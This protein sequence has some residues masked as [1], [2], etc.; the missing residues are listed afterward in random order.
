MRGLPAVLAALALVLTTGTADAQDR[1]GETPSPVPGRP[2]LTLDQD[3]L[4]AESDFGRRVREEIEE[5]ARALGAENRR[6]ESELSEEE[7]ALTRKRDEMAADAFR[8]LADAFDARV[9]EI[10]ER[11]DGKAR[12]IDDHAEAERKRFF[13]EVLPILLEIVR[14][15]GASAILEDRAIILAAE[16]LDI[17]DEAV[18][19]VN[20]RLGDGR[21]A[22]GGTG[23]TPPDTGPGTGAE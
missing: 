22:P 15:T 3:R 11:Q 10:R 23:D 16:S 1:R 20:A 18:R 7:R 6:I 21:E 12:E 19:R 14:E 5:R 4:F 2:F 13:A 9:V 17:T 8:T